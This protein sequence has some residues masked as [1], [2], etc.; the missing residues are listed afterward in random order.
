[1]FAKNENPS[2]FKEV[3]TTIGPSVKV[4]GDFV[5]QGNLI[6]EGVVKG[7]VKTDGNLRVGDQ[8]KIE[9]SISAANALISGEIKGDVVIKG[10]LE[11]TAGSK[12]WGDVEAGSICIARGAFFN[13]KCTMNDANNKEQPKEE[14]EEKKMEVE[15]QEEI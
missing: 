15:I 4:E 8:S 1:M 11:L 14:V 7:S 13:G 2:D 12:I 10:D 5:G 3:E 9:A 6:I